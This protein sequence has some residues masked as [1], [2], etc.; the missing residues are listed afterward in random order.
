LQ[1]KL[2]D[3]K[4]ELKIIKEKQNPLFNRKEIKASL[5]SNSAPQRQ[6]V[7][8]SLSEKYSIPVDALRV[9]T[10]KGSFGTKEFIIKAHIYSSNQER[11][12]YEKLTK[13]E[14]ELEEKLKAPVPKEEPKEAPEEKK[15]EKP[16]VEIKQEPTPEEDKKEKDKSSEEKLNEKELQA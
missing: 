16:A 4:M 12:K 11:E 15:E 10:I 14:K 8:K 13:K 3:S 9:L 2:D 7:I 1:L 5:I 6:E